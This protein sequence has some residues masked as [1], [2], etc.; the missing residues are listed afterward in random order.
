MP[1]LQTARRS[2]AP[3]DISQQDPIRLAALCRAWLSCHSDLI[4]ILAPNGRVAHVA[5][6]SAIL[7]PAACRRLTGMTWRSLWPADHRHAAIDAVAEARAGRPARFQ[8]AFAVASGDLHWWDAVAA[9]VAND[10]GGAPDLLILLRD[11]TAFKAEDERRAQARRLES[12]GRLVGGVAHDFNN[13]LT[14]VI[15]ASESLAAEAASEGDRRLAQVCCEAAERGAELIRRLLAFARP[16][17]RTASS[18]DCA[19]AVDSVAK[20]L[21]RTLPEQIRFEAAPPQGLVYC[22][23]DRGE[24]EAALLNLC[25]NARD[26]MPAGGRLSLEAAPAALDAAAAAALGLKPGRYARFR[27]QDTGVGMSPDTLSRAVEPF[28]STKSASGGTGLG[29]SSAQ[30]FARSCGGA[31]I[32]SSPPGQGVCAEIFIPHAKAAAQ[33]ELRLGDRRAPRADCDVLLVEDDPAVRAQTARLLQ[34]MGCRVQQAEDAQAAMTALTSDVPL[35]LMMTDMQLPYGLDGE[36]LAAAAVTLRPDL[37][38]LFTSGRLDDAGAPA[39]RLPANFVAKPFGRARL[40]EALLE[41]L[42]PQGP[43]NGAPVLRQSL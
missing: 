26:A 9:P 15:S 22:Q 8:G 40:A 18:A 42:A 11:I 14:V 10:A 28:F 13:L 6:A 7:D 30:S 25:I 33:T 17:S 5:Q 29:L 31:L 16:A 12:I 23:A 4:V 21:R 41:S 43:P 38:V 35:D 19:G 24:L 39:R 3:Q 36:E 1:R 2:T 32:L 37:K 20:L 27:V 34:A